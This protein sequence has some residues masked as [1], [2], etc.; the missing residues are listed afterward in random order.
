MNARLYELRDLLRQY[1][2]A[3]LRVD[4]EDVPIPTNH[5]RWDAALRLVE[6][7]APER[8]ELLDESGELIRAVVTRVHETPTPA[9]VPVIQPPAGTEHWIAL[10]MATQE[11][12]RALLEDEQQFRKEAFGELQTMREQMAA[13]WRE[14]AQQQQEAL[15]A[16]HKRALAVEKLIEADRSRFQLAPPPDDPD[17]DDA[18]DAT[19]QLITGIAQVASMAPQLL[20]VVRSLM[21]G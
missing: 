4:G 17:D 7:R 16:T 18:P 20:P 2:P 1:R 15:A 6:E 13:G 9:P 11:S 3:Q 8:V 12:Y 5:K 10:T 21:K 14:L 19:T